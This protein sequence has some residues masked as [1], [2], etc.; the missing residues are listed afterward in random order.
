MKTQIGKARKNE[1]GATML[2]VLI[3]IV[4]VVFGLLGLAGLQ[5]RMQA[6]ELESYQR[7]QALVLL[8]DMVDRLTT[9]RKNA[10]QYVTAEV[11][12][13]T[14]E[15]NCAALG[16]QHERDLCEWSNALLGASEVKDK[17][18]ANESNVGAMIGA[19]GCITNPV[20]TPPLEFEIAVAWQG[21]A[22]TTAPAISTCGQGDYGANEAF[23]RV[24]TARVVVACLKTDPATGLCAP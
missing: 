5:A 10:T 6:A 19:R 3:T 13:G 2:E 16:T 24:V 23:R 21:L 1:H 7:T 8:Q 4:I 12:S 20:A 22:A 9:N 11:G 14:A 15:A 17:G 18:G